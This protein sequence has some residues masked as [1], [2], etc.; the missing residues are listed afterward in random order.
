ME[1]ETEGE[2]E[3]EGGRRGE[4]ENLLCGDARHARLHC[5]WTHQPAVRI[6]LNIS[7]RNIKLLCGSRAL[8]LRR[9]HIKLLPKEEADGPPHTRAK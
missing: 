2:T 4:G 3:G 9:R 5:G 6:P 1:G 8:I 7:S